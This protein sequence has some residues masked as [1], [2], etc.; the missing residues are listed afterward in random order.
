MIERSDDL[1]MPEPLAPLETVK[2]DKGEVR[3][4]AHPTDETDPEKPKGLNPFE[5]PKYRRIGKDGKGDPV[6]PRMY[7]MERRGYSIFG[8]VFQAAADPAKED[9]G[10]KKEERPLPQISDNLWPTYGAF[11]WG[12]LGKLGES[13]VGMHQ[14]LRG[15]MLSRHPRTT[16]RHAGGV[17]P[18][19]HRVTAVSTLRDTVPTNRMPHVPPSPSSAGAR[20]RDGVTGKV[21]QT[22]IGSG[23]RKV[24]PP[25]AEM[26]AGGESLGETPGADLKGEAPEHRRAVGQRRGGGGERLRKSRARR[27]EG[28]DERGVAQPQPQLEQVE[29]QD[30]HQA[31]RRRRG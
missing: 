23:T 22:K 27:E 10:L 18:A 26:A 11:K 1:D 6:A 9:G 24:L 5:D 17:R 3:S 13:D 7:P 21:L 2:T 29:A 31:D 4:R 20:V 19:S 12:P 16:A 14:T 25:A 28:G 8:G 30:A 15:E